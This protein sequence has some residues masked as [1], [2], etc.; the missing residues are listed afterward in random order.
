MITQLL[1]IIGFILLLFGML[2]SYKVSYKVSLFRSIIICYYIEL[3]LGAM[4]AMIY[5]VVHIPIHLLSVG[6]GYFVLGVA[7]WIIII[8]KKQT[9]QLRIYKIDIYTFIIITIFFILLFVKLF[10]T[11]ISNIYTNSDPAAH[12]KMALEVV[13][14]GKVTRMYF[15]SLFNGLVIELLQPFMQEIS[16][17]KAFILADT[18]SNYTNLLIFYVLLTTV[19]RSNILKYLCPFISILY[20]MGW[21]FHSYVVGGFVYFQTG[22]ALFAC[23]IYFVYLYRH[24][25]SHKNKMVLLGLIVLGVFSETICYMLFTPILCLILLVEG[26]TIIKEE[27]IIVSKK[28]IL[29]G[30]I[31]TITLL[32]ILFGVGYFGYFGGNVKSVFEGLQNEGGIHQE[33]YKDFAFLFFP[34]IYMLWHRHWYKDLFCIVLT[35]V[36]F[37]TMA[38]LG[39]RILGVISSYYYYKLYYLIW[40]YAFLITVEA[41]ECWAQQERN[42]LYTYVITIIFM[43]VMLFV[44]QTS[45]LGKYHLDSANS[46]TLFPLYDANLRFIRDSSET[47]ERA[48]LRYVS[49]YIDENLSDVKIPYIYSTENYND[50]PWYEAFTLNEIYCVDREST[51]QLQN[52]LQRLQDSGY[53]YFLIMR[54]SD[55]YINSEEYIRNKIQTGEYEIIY[56]DGYVELLYIV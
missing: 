30:G 39:A 22:I 5:S 41:F 11:N 45:F 55:C 16:S 26:V 32:L 7:L 27:K 34:V 52:M 40:F 4:L 43:V 3:C 46:S 56:S 28:L 15:S 48:A 42:F 38:M 54:T 33:L 21:P 53:K 20:F 29:Y 49:K 37:V 19:L 8:Y 50:A 13:R 44:E 18:F 17:Y 1:F 9:Q 12:Y 51:E 31:G 35:V 10:T 23:V 25:D 14:T 47:G 2:F 6:I 36:L 24:S